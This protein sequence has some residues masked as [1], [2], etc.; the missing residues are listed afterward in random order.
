MKKIKWLLLL[1]AISTTAQ[2]NK[3]STEEITIDTELKGT[4]FNANIN[5]KKQIL[6]III[7]GSGPTNRSGNQ[8][9]MHNNSLKYLAQG[10]ANNGISVFSFDKRAIAQIISGKTDESKMVFEDNSTDVNQ[11][12]SYFKELKKY[13]KIVLI[14]HSEG[15]LIGMMSASK[16]IDGFVSIAGPGR[17]FDE[18]LN[19]QIAKQYPKSAAVTRTN[20]DILKSGKTF[21]CNSESPIIRSLFRNSVQNYLIS[22]IKI[23]PQLEIKKLQIPILLIN[24]TAD[25][26]VPENEAKI[27]KAAQ[28]KAELVIIKKMNHVFK[29][30][31]GDEAENKASYNNPKLPVAPEL[32]TSISE[33]ISKM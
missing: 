11:I 24:G 17:P 30:I 25:L 10:L 23:N 29:I 12:I 31:E 2:E 32:I 18:M 3:W 9:G 8:P 28:P 14:G 15:S 27:L 22:W 6:A 4:L 5:Q 26:Q 13:Y 33:F 21:D 16:N 19:E 20:L 1:F 7:A